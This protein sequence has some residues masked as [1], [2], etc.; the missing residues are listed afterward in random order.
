MRSLQS[1]KGTHNTLDVFFVQQRLCQVLYSS[2][3]DADVMVVRLQVGV[4]PQRLLAMAERGYKPE[5]REHLER[6]VNR[7]E[8]HCGNPR[9]DSAIH[10]F[11][12]RVIVT[13]GNL[14]KYLQPLVRCFD[15]LIAAGFS[16]PVEL[17]L[18]N[19]NVRHVPKSE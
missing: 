15:A 16:E 4:E 17:G 2:T 7:V 6:A 19:I 8:G 5:V 10:R 14:A 9:F 1:T 3:L 11:S 12:V 18:E 13:S